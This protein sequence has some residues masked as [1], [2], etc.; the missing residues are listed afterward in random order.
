M[1]PNPIHVAS[2]A[3]PAFDPGRLTLREREPS[4]SDCFERQN[5]NFL[6]LCSFFGALKVDTV[7]AEEV[8]GL[9]S[10]LAF[11]FGPNELPMSCDKLWMLDRLCRR[12][13][14]MV[15]SRVLEAPEELR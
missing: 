8:C 2:A 15:G 7:A 1:H 5:I 3:Q 9:N 14:I 13:A 11:A 12:S 4:A 10:S 6:S